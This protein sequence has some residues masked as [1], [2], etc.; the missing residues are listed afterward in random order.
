MGAW[1]EVWWVFCCTFVDLLTVGTL[2][3]RACN[4]FLNRIWY[5]SPLPRHKHA[6]WSLS[7]QPSPGC[8]WL[9]HCSQPSACQRTSRCAACVRPASDLIQREGEKDISK[10][11]VSFIIYL[12]RSN[13]TI[14]FSIHF[15]DWIRSRLI[16]ISPKC[17]DVREE[18]LADIKQCTAKMNMCSES[19]GGHTLSQDQCSIMCPLSNVL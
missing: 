4:L 14:S 16:D 15:C 7:G 18:E 1:T 6:G 8:P 3:G 12:K 13:V 5:Y 9:P 2:D 11:S 17:C 19:V 10:N